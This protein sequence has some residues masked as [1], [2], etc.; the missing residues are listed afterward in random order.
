MAIYRLPDKTLLIHSCIAVN[1]EVLKE[2][3]ALGEPSVLN[4]FL[5]S[6]ILK[7]VIVPQGFHRL[8]IAVWKQKF[9]KCKVICPKKAQTAVEKVIKVEGFCEDILPSYGIKCI[10]TKGIDKL[11]GTK[12]ME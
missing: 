5:I 9:P 10:S 6:F 3:L 12:H 11:Q 7:I 4:F 8:D 2:I 1:E